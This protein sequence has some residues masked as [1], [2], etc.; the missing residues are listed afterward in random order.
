MDI[1]T[2]IL[3]EPAEYLRFWRIAVIAMIATGLLAVSA[4]VWVAVEMRITRQVI[5][6]ALER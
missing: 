2:Q 4:C 5:L 1:P 3:T 6:S